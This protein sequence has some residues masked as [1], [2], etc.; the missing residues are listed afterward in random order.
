MANNYGKYIS[1]QTMDAKPRGS[2]AQPMATSN[3]QARPD[4][5]KSAALQTLGEQMNS[6]AQKVSQIN[7]YNET[8][9]AMVAIYNFN[10]QA[11]ENKLTPEEY[12]KQWNSFYSDLSS[13]ISK[14][15]LKARINRI[16]ELSQA[17]T[18][19][20]LTL[21]QIK[22][23]AAMAFTGTLTAIGSIAD[24]VKTAD[25][26][27]NAMPV[28]ERMVQDAQDNGV[29]KPAGA[30]TLLER[31]KKVMK[32]NVI[33]Q[34]LQNNPQAFEAQVKAGVYDDIL[35]PTEK[36][37]AIAAAK[38]WNLANEKEQ[39]AQQK[40]AQ[41][42][43]T[44]S[45]SQDINNLTIPNLIN[46]VHQGNITFAQAQELLNYKHNTEKSNLKAY[47][48][49]QSGIYS[50]RI[51]FIDELMQNPNFDKLSI[52]DK[53]KAINEVSVFMKTSESKSTA[54]YKGLIKDLSNK[55]SNDL[56]V[57]FDNLSKAFGFASANM[58]SAGAEVSSFEKHI[59]KS[60][61]ENSVIEAKRLFAYKVSKGVEPAKAYN[62]AIRVAIDDAKNSYFVKETSDIIKPIATDISTLLENYT[63]NGKRFNFGQ[64]EKV[65]S[66]LKGWL[67]GLMRTSRT[68]DINAIYK[69]FTANNNHLAFL[70]NTHINGK[71]YAVPIVYN[72]KKWITGKPIL[73]DRQ[74]PFI[75]QE[76]ISNSI[77]GG[78]IFNIF[79]GR[80]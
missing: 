20:D 37:N 50:G 80:Y 36:L 57:H 62:D 28:I 13:N 23:N 32:Q 75:T 17:S 72:G 9:N 43:N 51:T 42:K 7:D 11:K 54:Q 41:Y 8:T 78:S 5:S 12:Q 45:L 34:G 55:I 63:Y 24:K 67:V 68:T 6:L 19:A 53:R 14:P 33:S 64:N 25:D 1:A 30:L 70:A 48:A 35:S 26:Y 16:A 18:L 38:K 21:K 15:S 56:P 4:L 46:Q 44:L 76:Q 79:S 31:T 59:R 58:A 71:P 3:Y 69:A 27:K 40:I 61:I 39:L 77:S 66:Q 73:H 65:M 49:I 2:V 10:A 29:L 74:H 47:A 22:D 52:S 60:V